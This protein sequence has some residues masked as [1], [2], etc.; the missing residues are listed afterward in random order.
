MNTPRT[1][2][3]VAMAAIVV[4]SNIL[5]QHL[6]GQWLTWG[7]ITYPFAFL[8]TDLTNR[9]QGAVA[10]QR[11]VIDG[12]RRQQVQSCGCALFN[13]RASLAGELAK[14]DF[15]WFIPAVIKYR[16]LLGDMLLSLPGAAQ[17]KSY[18]VME[19]IKETLFLATGTP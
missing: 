16:K 11:V 5:V 10:A 2:H 14:F 17:S 1:A 19:E 9:L 6:F 12:E 13:A 8:V 15:T 7:A 18:V 3:S 4:L